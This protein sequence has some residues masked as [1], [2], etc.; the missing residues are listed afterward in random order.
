MRTSEALS[1]ETDTVAL[2]V[3]RCDFKLEYTCVKFE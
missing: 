3:E 2:V 1:I